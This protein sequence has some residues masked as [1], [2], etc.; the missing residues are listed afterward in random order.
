MLMKILMHGDLCYPLKTNVRN[1]INQLYYSTPIE[2]DLYNE[3]IKTEL[4]FLVKDLNVI[5]TIIVKQIKTVYTIV[6]PVR[7][8]YYKTYFFLY[9]EQILFSLNYLFCEKESEFFRKELSK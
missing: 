5:I 1:Y 6:H 3:I 2:E 4:P 8:K 9:I 7:Y